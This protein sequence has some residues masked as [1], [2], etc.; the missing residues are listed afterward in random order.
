[1]IDKGKVEG[2]NY[3]EIDMSLSGG[4]G[5]ITQNK[6]ILLLTP[7]CEKITAVLHE[8]GSDIWVISHKWNSDAFYSF[9][10]TQNGVSQNPV[11]S[12]TG[13]LIN[14]IVSNTIGYLKASPDGKKVALANFSQNNY[15]VEIC[16]FDNSTGVI[17]N[18][19]VINSSNLNLPYGVEFSP[20]S[21]Y[22]YISERDIYT[23]PYSSKLYQYDLSA[24]DVSYSEVILDTIPYIGGALQLG[25][26]GK[27]YMAIQ[28]SYYLYMINKPD[29][30]GKD[31]EVI[32][33]AIH[34]GGK[35]SRI[36]LPPFIQSYFQTYDFTFKNTCLLDKTEFVC[37][38]SDIDEIS[39]VFG[40]PQSISNYAYGVNTTHTFSEPGTYM[41]TMTTTKDG[42][43]N[44]I[45]KEINILQP[46]PIYLED[47]IFIC[48]QETVELNPKTNAKTF[49]WSD[50]S[51][52]PTLKVSESGTY[53]LL[54]TDENDC[55]NSKDVH[56]A[57]QDCSFFLPSAFSPNGDGINDKLYLRGV[58][59]KEFDL[60]IYNRFGELVF[61]SNNLNDGWNGTFNGKK[62]NT[63]VYIS[64][65]NLRLNNG[66]EKKIKSNITTLF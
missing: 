26:D 8:N 66:V 27:I 1:V 40:D 51:T 30:K 32:A 50:N 38:E 31:C 58:G 48:N 64:V 44:S 33:N 47:S 23:Q 21:Q 59:I 17:S 37:D 65:L 46:P 3:S 19:F 57:N 12:N 36:G 61:Y 52:E 39:W 56:I 11:I 13:I 14:G 53:S 41:V 18:G 5:A 7:T 43:T 9:I 42:I 22:L 16:D 63:E 28:D 34:L 29:K 25:P 10:V 20:L 55:Q 49:E 4:L 24:P 35:Y 45:T 54:I 62:T 2:L 60:M 6:N 15:K